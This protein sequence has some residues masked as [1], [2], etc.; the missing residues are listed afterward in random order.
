MER[1][2]SIKLYE[3][4]LVKTK[5]KGEEKRKKNEVCRRVPWCWQFSEACSV[6]A[7]NLLL[8]AVVVV[9]IRLLSWGKK[10]LS[11]VKTGL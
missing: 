8:S 9:G 11:R 1:C 10:L 2:V 3:D 5:E 6:A 4:L 7:G